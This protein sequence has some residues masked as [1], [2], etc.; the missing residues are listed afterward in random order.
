[1]SLPKTKNANTVVEEK[2]SLSSNLFKNLVSAISVVVEEA[3]FTSSPDGTSF[4]AMSPNHVCLLDVSI[5]SAKT[6]QEHKWCLRSEDLRKIA[7]RT[8]KEDSVQFLVGKDAVTISL[9][10]QR[11]R[12]Y[13]NPIL[14]FSSSET[15]LPKLTFNATFQADRVE[16][17]DVLDDVS[18]KSNFVVIEMT[19][20]LVT[21]SGKGDSGSVSVTLSRTLSSEEAKS[22]YSIDR[23]QPFLKAVNVEFVQFYYGSKT[24]L[25]MDA[26]IDDCVM[27]YFVAPRV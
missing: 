18:V 22:S 14:E 20:H 26:R 6:E 15:S 13:E 21:L 9:L 25:C 11:K 10:G 24:P 2:F 19:N 23:L 27:R 7:S 3:Q 4:R 17:L 16:F 12:V 5:P 8:K 1:M